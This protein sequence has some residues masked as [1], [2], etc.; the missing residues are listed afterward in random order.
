MWL[1]SVGWAPLRQDC[2][3]KGGC[4]PVLLASGFGGLPGGVVT[5]AGAAWAAATP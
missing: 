5:T 2:E 3:Q 1:V 4:Q